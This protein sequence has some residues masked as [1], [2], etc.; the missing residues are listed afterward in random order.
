MIVNQNRIYMGIV[1]QRHV[2]AV[3]Q[4]LLLSYYSV[5]MV[6]INAEVIHYLIMNDDVY[7]PPRVRK[8]L[9]YPDI[10]MFSNIYRYISQAVQSTTMRVDVT[11]VHPSPV[12]GSR[13]HDH[14]R[15]R[16][17]TAGQWFRRHDDPQGVMSKHVHHL[18]VSVEGTR[19]VGVAVTP[20]LRKST[21][22]KTSDTVSNENDH[23]IYKHSI[24][25]HETDDVTRYENLKADDKKV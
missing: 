19:L 14:S 15:S 12:S 6:M 5:V 23:I 7:V 1:Q 17:D 20:G 11:Q 24:Q 22:L 13:T 16:V 3:S 9:L 21:L 8:C 18:P 25:F 4:H 2:Q 10:I